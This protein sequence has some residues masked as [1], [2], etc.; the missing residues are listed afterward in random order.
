VSIRDDLAAVLSTVDGVKGYPKAPAAWNTGDGWPLWSGA[1]RWE[2]SG[3][4]VDTWRIMIVLPSEE[5]AAD[6]WIDAHLQALVDAISPVAFIDSMVPA[7]AQASG[8]D[9]YR[10]QITVRE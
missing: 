5:G 8:N 9:I 3:L 1:N 4:F 10:L 2:D 6:A 7:L